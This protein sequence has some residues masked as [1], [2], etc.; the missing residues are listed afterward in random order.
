M[1]HRLKLSGQHAVGT[2]TRRERE[3]RGT[4]FPRLTGTDGAWSTDAPVSRIGRWDPL[5]P[6]RLALRPPAAHPAEDAI[7]RAERRL[8]NLRHILGYDGARADEGPRAA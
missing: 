6:H 8:E 4:A 2:T 7:E 5:P 3:A 1:G